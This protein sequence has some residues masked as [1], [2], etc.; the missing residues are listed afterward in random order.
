MAITGRTMSK[1]HK[2]IQPRRA[3]YGKF[4]RYYFEMLSVS[5]MKLT[6]PFMPGVMPEKLL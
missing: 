3:A 2:K 5:I 6:D 4:R 1:K